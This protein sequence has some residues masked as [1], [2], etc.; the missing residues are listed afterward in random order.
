MA[1]R[2]DSAAAGRP[3]FSSQDVLAMSAATISRVL[4]ETLLAAMLFW[5]WIPTLVAN[6][7][8]DRYIRAEMALN[9]IPGLALATVAHGEI[10]MVRA[11]GVQS[12]E[13]GRAMTAK[14]PVELASLSKALTALAVL[15]AE[16]EGLIE[17]SSRAAEVLPGL[18]GTS[19]A[20][21][22]LNHLLQHSSG[23]RRRHDFLLPCCL[24]P[25]DLD[26]KVAVEHLS[27]ADL[28]GHPGDSESYANSNY[29][30]LAAIIEHTS[31]IPFADYMRQRVFLPL[32]MRQASLAE[33]SQGTQAAAVPH[34]W[35]WAR[36]RISPSRFLGWTGSSL[37]KAS[38]ADMAA[39]LDVLLN[40][41]SGDFEFLHSSGPWWELL[42]PG[43]D[44]GWSV[45]ENPGWL[46]EDLILEHTGNIWG[47]HTA[48]IVAPRSH[49]AVAVLGNLGTSRAR[50]IAR[51][52]M[53]SLGGT[54]LPVAERANR[55]E[56]P[57]TW[58]IVLLAI[59]IVLGGLA[60]W[61]GW[62]TSHQLQS[63]T[64]EWQPNA[65]RIGR[66]AILGALAITLVYRY[67]WGSPPHEAFPTTI[68]TAL[69]FL[70]TCV[71]GVLLASAIRGLTA[72]PV[73]MRGDAS[74]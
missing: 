44:L 21:V 1:D 51:A 30:L 69:P 62:L 47:G 68:Q 72:T 58:A 64:R 41:K 11:Y 48:A 28:E 9:K 6:P 5:A 71:C 14:T 42:E 70:V 55:W 63:G 27:N 46:D 61:F 29:V 74:P 31:G 20:G 4:C 10:E 19:W 24:S 34:E 17:R 23:L 12:V 49:S 13:S 26:M 25:N 33:T 36:V 52:I 37:A 59:A 54:K 53:R 66:S 8:V 22:T 50:T 65:W 40:L 67:H 32:G 38:A 56:I 43:Y 2:D 45:Q 39:Y 16:R 15:R 35:Q 57:D 60:G 7:E 3:P 73:G 18:T